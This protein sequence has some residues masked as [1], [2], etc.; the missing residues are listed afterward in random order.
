MERGDT[1]DNPVPNMAK[2]K[3]VKAR[4]RILADDELAL[5]WKATDKMRAPLGTFYRVLMLTGQ[6]RDEVQ[7]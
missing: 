3:G 4:D 2:P 1:A 7:A 5:I 6:R